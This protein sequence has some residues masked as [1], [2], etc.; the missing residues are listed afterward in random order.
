MI[1]IRQIWQ[2]EYEQGKERH[3]TALL[4]FKKKRGESFMEI[5]L[6]A[7]FAVLFLLSASWVW[8]TRSRM[9]RIMEHLNGM[10]EA[11]ADGSF[12]EEVYDES[13]LSSIET[14]MAHYLAASAVSA[15]NLSEEK[16]KVKQLIADISHQTKTPIAN[17]L[18]YAQMLE[19]K[20]LSGEDREFVQEINRQAQKLNFL[21]VSL[22]KASRLETGM[23]VL[24]PKQ[25]DVSPMLEEVIS[26]MKPKADDKNQAVEFAS[27]DHLS[28]CFDWKWTVEAIYNIV[29]NAVKYTPAGGN[30]RISLMD[31]ELFV[32]IEIRDSGIGIAEADTPKIFQRF[33]RGSS[34]SVEEGVGIGL[35]L[36]RRIITGENGYLKVKSKVGEGSS[37]FVY[38]PKSEEYVRSGG[39]D[40]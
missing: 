1:L 27:Q 32:R 6:C 18:L 11:A 17:L 39:W 5:V 3:I 22:V 38:L 10:L 9:R 36:T 35:Y 2:Q 16:E 25:G 34:V 24:H 40:H 4:H 13:V 31:T 21:I 20:R 19:E 28:A 33:Y 30:I 29:D 15:R 12:Q 26:Q 23:F 8:Y 37:F 7:A 14:K